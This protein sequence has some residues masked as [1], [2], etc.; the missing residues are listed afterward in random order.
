MNYA[1]LKNKI[2]DKKSFLCIGLDSDI[3]KIPQFLKEGFSDPVLEFNRRIIESTSDI[4]VAYKINSAFYESN[5]LEGWKTLEATLKLI[6]KDIF[7]ILDAKRADIGN[8]SAQ[9]AKAAFESLGCD[10]VTVNPY[11][12]YDSVEPFLNYEG[13]WT[14]LLALTSNEGSRDFQ[15]LKVSQSNDYLYNQVINQSKHWGSNENMMY[16]I[17]AT[18]PSEFKKVRNIIPDHFILIPGVGAQGGNLNEVL[19]N[20]LN[21]NKSLLIN[22]SRSIIFASSGID[23]DM[24]AL[25]KSKELQREMEKYF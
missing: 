17:G 9:Y 24:L 13:K 3:G 11:M 5:G 8:T 25:E 20:A 15:Y 19:I 21:H 18:H 7:I 10:A 6:P 4:A 14:I 22:V 12:G 16:V 1:Q 2:F 23:F